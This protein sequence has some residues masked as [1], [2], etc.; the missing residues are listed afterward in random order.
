[1]PVDRDPNIV[2][3][4]L[5]GRVTKHG[6]SVEVE[7]YRLEGDPMWALEVVDHERGSTVWNEQFKSDEEAL[8]AFRT[9]IADEGIESFTQRKVIP[10]PKRP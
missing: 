10:F 7:I 5:S 3:S 2:R 4:G 8:A 1:M 6:L 9:I